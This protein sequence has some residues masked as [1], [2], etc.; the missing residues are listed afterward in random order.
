MLPAIALAAALSPAAPLPARAEAG[1]LAGLRTDAYPWVL[2]LR[3]AGRVERYEVHAG[4]VLT[5]EGRRAG[6]GELPGL[7]RLDGPGVRGSGPVWT[8]AG[9]CRAWTR[10]GRLE[11]LEISLR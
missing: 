4:L 5:V 3:H 9:S 8:R 2:L 1:R 7:F 11:A 6:L 10:G